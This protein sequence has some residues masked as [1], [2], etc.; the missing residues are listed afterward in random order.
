MK[1]NESL[2]STESKLGD[3]KKEIEALSKKIK[4]SENDNTKS[5][6]DLK[7]VTTKLADAEEVNR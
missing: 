4:D 2:Q 1:T 5:S 7:S 3:A 6:D